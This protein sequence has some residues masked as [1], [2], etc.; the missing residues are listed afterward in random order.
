MKNSF[1]DSL[2]RYIDAGRPL[3]YINHFDFETID[4]MLAGA[5]PQASIVEYCDAE[6]WVDFKTKQPRGSAA[7]SLP[8]FLMLFNN[9]QFYQDKKEYIV[10]L[11]EIHDTIGDKQVYSILQAIA[12]RKFMNES[13]KGYNITIVIVDSKLTIPHELEKLI[14]MIELRPPQEEEICNLLNEILEENLLAGS[15]DEDTMRELVMAFSGLSV[16]EIKQI[17]NLALATDGELNKDSKKLILS[18]KKQAIQKSGLLELIEP[19]N[20]EIGG[21]ENLKEYL[22]ANKDVFSNPGIAAAHGIDMPAG[23]MIVGMPGC[24]KSLTAK[25]ISKE[26]GVPLLRLD[27]GRL[28]GKYVGES[29]ENLRKAIRVAEATTP[30]ILWIDEIEKAFAG[31]GSGGEVT[32]RLFGQFLTW[33]Q[34]KKSAIYVVAT[35]NDISN[36]PPEFLRRGRFDEI[37]Q[38]QFPNHKE[39]KAILDIQLRRRNNDKI[40][41]GINIDELAAALQDGANYSG[42]DLESI[43]KEAMKKAF[44]DGMR[45][46]KQ[47]DI[48]DVI[49]NTKSSY[50]S[51][52][53]K[54]DKMLE[55]LKSLGVKPASK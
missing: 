13:G 12:R 48:L 8:E 45:T 39:R 25:C 53:D 35:A 10:V 24:G 52:K 49:K 50:L 7:Y 27:I 29:E 51:Q 15:V 54:L 38:V 17:V 34:E 30:C 47:S 33:M 5:F 11:K 23:V 36:L 19:G 4:K 16:F 41:D 31:I 46:V 9:D 26:F 44:S 37:F 21:L 14:T 42:A 3:I 32:T 22:S 20:L 55:K 6:G 43:V 1:Q 18:E 40:P 28:M 2:I